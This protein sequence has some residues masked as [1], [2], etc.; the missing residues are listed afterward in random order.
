MLSYTVEDHIFR[1]YIVGRIEVK[2][3]T[4]DLLKG[5]G[6][7]FWGLLLQMTNKFKSIPTAP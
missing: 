2:D 6:F 4:I 1:K 5:L 7:V 3:Q